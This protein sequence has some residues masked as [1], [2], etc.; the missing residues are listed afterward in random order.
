[1]RVAL[2]GTWCPARANP[3]QREGS[4]SMVF[5]IPGL[6]FSSFISGLDRHESRTQAMLAAASSPWRW[7][8]LFRLSQEELCGKACGVHVRCESILQRGTRFPGVKVLWR[9]R[10]M[11]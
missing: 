11:P 9:V 4:V 10:F 8:P 2:V 1:M 5:V 6:C 7:S 3:P